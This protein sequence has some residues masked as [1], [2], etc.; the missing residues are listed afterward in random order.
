MAL[1]WLLQQS[2]EGLETYFRL[3]DRGGTGSLI[4]NL[5]DVRRAAARPS[6]P[7]VRPVLAIDDD[8]FNLDLFEDGITFVSRRLAE[9]M[10]LPAD[11][12]ELGEVDDRDCGP[13]VRRM[14]YCTLRLLA[15]GNA[16]DHEA[17]D[18]RMVDWVDEDGTARSE[19]VLAAPEPNRPAPR[20]RWWTDFR[21][22]A[23]LFLVSGTSWRAATDALA[24]RVMNMGAGGLAFVDPVASAATG[25]LVTRVR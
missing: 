25:D 21:P 15:R 9:T 4:R 23:E 19:W 8:A 22:P 11:A 24:A 12:A 10:A 16:L 2:Y 1:L 7:Q 6:G 3:A 18:G 5:V 14:S 20:A 13:G 17:S